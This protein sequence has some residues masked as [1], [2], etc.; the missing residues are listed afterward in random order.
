MKTT[1]TP[2]KIE[3]L[4]QYYL[5]VVPQFHIHVIKV[6]RTEKKHTHTR[7][8]CSRFVSV[9]KRVTLKERILYRTEKKVIET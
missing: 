3:R 1:V 6:K 4:V 2:R 5:K 8:C 9:Y 7:T